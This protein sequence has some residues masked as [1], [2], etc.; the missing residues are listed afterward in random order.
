MSSSA[1]VFEPASGVGAKAGLHG[2]ADEKDGRESLVIDRQTG[3]MSLSCQF[4]VW[5]A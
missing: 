3:S 4:S 1:Y 5:T 2:V